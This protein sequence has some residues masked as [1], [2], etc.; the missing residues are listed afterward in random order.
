MFKQN[1]HGCI[2]HIAVV[3]EV[4]QH[5]RLNNKTANINWFDLNDAF[6]S[7]PHALIP[8]VLQHYHI[9]KSVITYI[10]SLYTKLQGTVFTAEWISETFKFLRGVFQG[11][12]L[13]GIIFLI[14]FN[15]II[16]YIKKHTETHGYEIKTTN[17]NALS[18]ITTPFA[19]GF[20]IIT[21]D[22]ALHQELV[23]DVE[24]KIQ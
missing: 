14:V 6:G 23:T 20:N 2:E 5:A 9:P 13:S 22:K 4:I 15:P 3:Q 8:H 12:P 17:L 7:G 18:V 19:D 11:D 21:R 1:F 24:K 16:E 10:T